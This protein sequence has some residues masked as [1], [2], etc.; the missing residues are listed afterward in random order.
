MIYSPPFSKSVSTNVAKIFFQLVPKH[1]P[2]SHKL[3]KIFNRNMKG[4]NKKVTTKPRDQTPKCNCIKEA[5]CPLE[6]NYHV[7]DVFYKCDIT[8]PLLK[9]VYLGLAK[10]EWKTRFYNHESSFRH[11]RYSNKTI[12]SSYMWYL[13]RVSCETPNLKWSVF[14]YIPPYSNISKKCLLCLY[15]KLETITCYNQKELLSK[16]SELPFKCRHTSTFLLKSHT[17]NDFR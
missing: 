11:K 2:R 15:K 1:Y 3:H 10:G 16:R 5:E 14:R 4:N 7:K 17:S 8:R 6:G 13:A 9:K 12:L